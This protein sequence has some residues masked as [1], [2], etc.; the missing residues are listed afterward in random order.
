MLVGYH[1]DCSRKSPELGEDRIDAAHAKGRRPHS[2][3]PREDW[4]GTLERLVLAFFIDAEGR[5]RDRVGGG[6][7]DGTRLSYEE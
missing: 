3:A 4:R 5:G 1:A 7:D 6:A 2:R